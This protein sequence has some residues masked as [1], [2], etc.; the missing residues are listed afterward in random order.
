[1]NKEHIAREVFKAIKNSSIESTPEEITVNIR[2]DIKKI[3]LPPSIIVFQAAAFLCSTKLNSS[4]NRILMYFFS[5]SAY[6]NF[7]GID[8]KM[9]M[10]ELNVSKPTVVNA[11]KD[12]EDSNILIKYQNVND[13]RRHDYFINPIT[14]WK[15]NS[16]TRQK[17]INKIKIEDPKQLDL[18]NIEPV[19]K[20][21]KPQL[22]F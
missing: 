6:E 22:D 19:E 11:L 10:E 2:K 1:M 15:G 21:I 9:L 14:A 4:A 18:F 13:K 17:Q 3:P 8:V 20:S 12:L 16:F 7:V 5:K